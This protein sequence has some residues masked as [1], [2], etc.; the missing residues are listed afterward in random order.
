MCGRFTYLFTW[1]QLHKLLRLGSWPV[2]ELAPRYNVAPTQMAPVVRAAAGAREGVMLR[3]GLVPPWADDLAIGSR[4]I[5]A[6]GETLAEK[7]AFRPALAKRRCLVPVTGFYEWRSN[8]GQKAKTPLWIGRA[9]RQPLWL[10]GLWE[11]WTKGDATVESF[12]II[13]VPPNSL[14]RS[15][16]DRMPV[17]LPD[18]RVEA[19]LDPD[20][21]AAAVAHLLVTH[22]VDDIELHEVSAR[23]N[24]PRHDDSSILRGVIA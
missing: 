2:E 11:R 13:T 16:H 8:P 21:D 23:V 1:T 17:I 4:M 15:V 5:N 10:A 9:T 3:W 19:W 22:E 6:R 18:D 24:N 14:L 7:P 20:R 12:T